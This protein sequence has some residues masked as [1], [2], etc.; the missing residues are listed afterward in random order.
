MKAR[1]AA[2]YWKC[3]GFEVSAVDYEACYPANCHEGQQMAWG[4]GYRGYL[5]TD[6][7]WSLGQSILGA[8]RTWFSNRI[9]AIISLI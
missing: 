4:K 3:D 1:I 6:G 7:H 9:R 2:T 5:G 8:D